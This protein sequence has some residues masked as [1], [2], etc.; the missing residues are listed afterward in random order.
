L[1]Q[2]AHKIILNLRQAK[3]KLEELATAYGN[4]S[5]ELEYVE[6]MLAAAEKMID[7]PL[8]A[9]HTS[10]HRANEWATNL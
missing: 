10:V 4:V 2:E 8:Q 6:F 5:P 3:A 9:I 1:N 7:E